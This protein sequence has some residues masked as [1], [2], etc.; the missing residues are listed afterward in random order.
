MT[1]KDISVTDIVHI[2]K[3]AACQMQ[4]KHIKKL[5]DLDAAIGD[6]DLGITISKGFKAMEE[7]LSIPKE[8]KINKLLKDIGMAF[9]E[10]ASSTFGTFFATAF[11][12]AGS[13]VE[14]KEAIDVGDLSRMFQ[15]AVQGIIKRGRANLGDKTILDALIPASEAVKQVAEK[16]GSIYE[17]L[18][19]ATSAAKEGVERTKDLRA[20]TG[21][22]R[23]FGERTKG[24]QDPGA[25]ALY[26]FLSEL[27]N[28][29]SNFGQ[30]NS[31]K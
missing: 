1:S 13:A 11:I 23:S 24:V 9:N 16:D 8:V 19:R 17:A 25:T 4:E 6:G 5:R 21:R 22:A 2:L 3:K 20:K 10:A 29:L 15:A 31:N 18:Q 27:L 28:S 14:D 30:K 7:V 12:K 26:F